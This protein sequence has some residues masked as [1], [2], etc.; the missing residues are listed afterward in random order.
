MGASAQKRRQRTEDS[1]LKGETIEINQ[2]YKPQIADA[3]R[4]A[5]E[6]E[7][8]VA[9]TTRPVLSYA[10]PLNNLIYVYHRI[11]LQPLEL[12]LDTMTLPYPNYVSLGG[13]NLSTIT[14]DAG[15]GRLFHSNNT[16]VDLHYFSQQGDIANQNYKEGRGS[17]A[18][19]VRFKNNL[20][21]IGFDG[22]YPGR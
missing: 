5:I 4:P 2:S 7:F 21:H 12:V 16:T 14:F 18:H 9:D 15:L 6:P 17:I 3:I 11:P 22:K 1:T 19:L 10:V 20:L 8:P 13:G